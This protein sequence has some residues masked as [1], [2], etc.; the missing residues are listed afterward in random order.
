MWQLKKLSTNEALSEAGPLPNNWGP[1]FG[2]ANVQEKLGDLSWLGEA[3]ADQ[4]WVQVD[5]SVIETKQSSPA[6]IAWGKAK[7]LLRQS[8]WSV[9]TDVP[10]TVS[11]RQAWKDYRAELRNIR[12]QSGFP[13]N[14]AWPTKPE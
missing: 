3:Y 5:D 7:D 11:E 12:M 4:G 14:I 10:M 2:M 6:E 9:L 8:D 1:I 13:A